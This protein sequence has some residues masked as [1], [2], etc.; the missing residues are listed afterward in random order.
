M[1]VATLSQSIINLINSF[2]LNS[3]LLT[4]IIS[5]ASYRSL[6][7]DRLDP[8]HCKALLQTGHWLDGDQHQNWQPESCTINRFDS[9]SINHCLSQRD[10]VFI[11]DSVT[12]VLF[13][14]TIRTL[15]SSISSENQPK[16]SDRSIKTAQNITWNFI[17]DPFL[18]SSSWD[19]LI[20][21]SF[22]N[23]LTTSSSSSS[24]SSS[25]SSASSSASI[26]SSQKANT[27][28]QQPALLV[29]GS[30]IWFL[31]HN[32]GLKPWLAKMDQ[33][34]SASLDHSNRTSV[35]DEIVILPVELPVVEK[36]SIER[37]LTISTDEIE[38]M[39][40]Y[41]IKKLNSDL[42]YPIAI[43]TVF[44]RITNLSENETSDGL[45]FSDR[46]AQV[47]ARIILNLRCNDQLPKKFPFDSTCCF[48]YPT[49]NLIQ[50]F[51]ILLSILPPIL[52]LINHPKL[53]PYSI[54]K[55]QPLIP[56]KENLRSISI[57]SFSILLIYLADRTNLFSKEQKQFDKIQFGFLNLLALLVGILTLKESERG[58]DLG[59]LNREQTDEWKGW[60]QIAIL[61][62]HYLG[63]SKVSGIYNPIRICVAS[64][65]FMTGYG[66]FTFYYLKKD[67]GLARV[68]NVLVRLNLLTIVLS[69]VMDTDYLSYYFSPLVSMWY[70][71]IW[72]TM[73]VGH[74]Y[75]DR[76]PVMVIKLIISASLMTI[77][78]KTQEPLQTIFKISN[79][80]LFTN[81]SAKEWSFRV[82]LDLYI[83]YFGMA[84]ESFKT[85]D[86]SKIVQTS[87]YVS[88]VGMLSRSNKLEYNHYHPYISVLPIACFIVL[89]NCTPYLR[90]INS[91]FFCYFGRC[92]LE[93]FIIQFHFWLAG[94]T[95][96]ILK[97]IDI[98]SRLLNFIIS[99]LIFV[100]ISNEVSKSTTAI[101]SLLCSKPKSLTTT[102][103]TATTTMR[104]L[105]GSSNSDENQRS[106]NSSYLPV[107]T[108]EIQDE[109]KLA[110][111]SSSNNYNN[112]T[113]NNYDYVDEE[114]VEGE[115]A[116]YMIV[117]GRR[118]IESQSRFKRLA[119]VFYRGFYERSFR[120]RLLVWVFSLWILNLLS[121]VFSGKGTGGFIGRSDGG[122]S[123]W[124]EVHL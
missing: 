34:F 90:S 3:I 32:L 44:N 82:T 68:L 55:F 39:N 117:R 5:L 45:H 103:A 108:V 92:S 12:R 124:D 26:Q 109:Q 11:G 115:E 35:A 113:E 86:R 83:V 15:D 122:E 88:M 118:M 99:S 72:L 22:I 2:Y 95:K 77:L 106:N 23:Q 46:L 105:N 79:S 57:F 33:L 81:W 54:K 14:G 116:S 87:I 30:G 18:N 85:L 96:G 25:A 16:H 4:L 76:L 91:S 38:E 40:D 75:N 78:F 93:T 10:V 58:G 53:I 112:D 63:A 49:P 31:R 71:V 73:F 50:I 37:K 101:T 48:R 42:N 17:W 62:Y 19:H 110:S 56:S 52:L 21:K 61:I 120:V 114:E 111:L 43:P 36:L 94:D 1:S 60:M 100:F 20:N 74:Q 123:F 65:L 80:I 27:L 69:F 104:N 6:I 28:N 84:K 119:R 70:L 64:Y 98:E 51:F 66:H 97:I 121:F 102:A 59:F 89:R 47:Q 8:Y 41:N 7:R 67:Y 13:Y 24:S 9:S 29:V 107:S